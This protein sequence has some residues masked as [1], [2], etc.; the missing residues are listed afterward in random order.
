[1]KDS[2]SAVLPA[3][4][5]TDEYVPGA[6]RDLLSEADGCLRGGFLTGGTACAR[7]ALDLLL[8]VAKADGATYEERLQY[9]GEKHGIS[10]MLT[11]I[12][13]QCGGAS[14]RDNATLSVDVLQLFVVT[15]KAVVYELYVVGPERT[16]RL[17]YVSRLVTS[18]GR[19]P[20]AGGNGSPSAASGDA[21]DSPAPDGH[22]RVLV[23]GD[24]TAE[25]QA[26]G[27]HGASS[28]DHA[29]RSRGYRRMSALSSTSR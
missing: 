28:G 21:D 10:K 25:S 3:F 11:S 19:K 18:V 17:Q 1:M 16:L 6:F 15:M 22:N 12:L 2:D 20:T 29:E 7:R 24:D 9:L 14:A 13:V 8:A 23:A 26:S 5:A 4:L 27:P